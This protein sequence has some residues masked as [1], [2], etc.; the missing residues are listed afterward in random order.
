MQDATHKRQPTTP[1]LVEEL[2]RQI[3]SGALG[4]PGARFLTVRKLAENYK[5]SLVT[6]QRIMTALR[7]RGF[8]ILNGNKSQIAIPDNVSSGWLIGMVVTNLENPFFA[9]LARETQRAVVGTGAKMVIAGSDCDPARER[10]ILE[11]FQKAGVNGV[12]ACPGIAP[13]T[14]ELYAK[15]K[16]PYVFIARDLDGLEADA[17]LADN[18]A[19]AW[20]TA[21]HFLELGRRE[22][23]YIGLAGVN[24]DPRWEGF[25]AG[26]G[27]EPQKLS[28]DIKGFERE[29]D[30]V[31][32]FLS[33]LP[34][35]AAV[36]CFH[37]LLAAMTLR[38][39]A[40]TGVRVP[41]DLAVA[42]FDDLPIAAN[43]RLTSSAYPIRDMAAIAVEILMD[44]IARPDRA[45]PIKR[46]L[47]TTL[48]VRESTGAPA[49]ADAEE[50]A[51]DFAAYQFS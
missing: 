6:A 10:D 24:E 12:L 25:R 5:V 11:M 51:Y 49:G 1:R 28:L 19:A 16:L 30:R 44:K 13:E 27:A 43:L 17:V 40:R 39:C 3:L 34:K 23:A 32:A 9:S 15:L 45:R 26:A 18:R 29:D 37:D 47:D 46:L 50:P 42:G 2:Q 48:V 41:H 20:K 4:A 22:L 38:I 31:A 33:R 14:R 7:D 8:V 35:P 36:F 21:R